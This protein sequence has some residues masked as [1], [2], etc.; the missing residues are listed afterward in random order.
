MRRAG[1]YAAMI[2]F[3]KRT[4]LD[5]ERYDGF[6]I[7]GNYDCEGRLKTLFIELEKPIDAAFIEYLK[8]F[9]YP[10][11]LPGNIIEIRR[12]DFFRLMLPTGRT[13]F[14]AK[15]TPGHD[16]AARRLLLQ[17]VYRGANARFRSSLKEKCPEN[18]IALSENAF[19]ID[20]SRCNF[21][22]KCVE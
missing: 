21:C 2:F 4:A 7:Q 15:F 22:L 18:A 14:Q 17:Q 6:R 13:G 11:E 9:G 16:P 20:L 1:G 12:D 3:R 10:F 19:S 5:V 8:P